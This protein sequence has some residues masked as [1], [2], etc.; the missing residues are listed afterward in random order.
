MDIEGTPSRSAP[1]VASVVRH[2]GAGK[3]GKVVEGEVEE[4]PVELDPETKVLSAL[5]ASLS[6]LPCF[7]VATRNCLL[8]FA[9]VVPIMLRRQRADFVLARRL[10]IRSCELTARPCWA[11]RSSATK[12]ISRYWARW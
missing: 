8:R 2:K 9:C 12:N 6:S 7:D 10:L 5:P 3:K 1:P 11:P 4:V